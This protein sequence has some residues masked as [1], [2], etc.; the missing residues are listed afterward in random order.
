MHSLGLFALV[1][2]GRKATLQRYE[3][4][5]ICRVYNHPTDC[6]KV[7]GEPCNARLNQRIEFYRRVG[8][9]DCEIPSTTLIQ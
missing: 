4:S 6:R 9:P 5:T 2:L 3:I 1:F 7:P 8:A